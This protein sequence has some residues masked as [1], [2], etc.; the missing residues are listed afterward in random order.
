MKYR[1]RLNWSLIGSMPWL[2]SDELVQHDLRSSFED[3][4]V[5]LSLA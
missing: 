5:S 2:I 3:L 1:G 4:L